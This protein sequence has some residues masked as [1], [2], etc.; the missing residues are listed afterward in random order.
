LN[1]DQ[2]K[3]Y[4]D[5]WVVDQYAE[6][7]GLRRAEDYL[8]ERYF[9]KTDLIYDIG[10][11]AGRTT[12]EISKKGFSIIGMD[13]SLPMI[14][15]CRSRNPNL[16]WQV[17]D[18]CHMPY[19]PAVFDITLFSYNGIDTIVPRKSR[20]DCLLE[21][22]RVTKPGGYLIYSSRNI[23]YR[24]FNRF[25]EKSVWNALRVNLSELKVQLLQNRRL[26]K[27]GYILQ[28]TNLEKQLNVYTITLKKNIRQFQALAPHW[29]LVEVVGLDPQNQDRSYLNNQCHMNYF[30]WQKPP[31]V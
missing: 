21:M 17:N 29:K 28:S 15:H 22:M 16:N 14:E 6:F 1:L 30:V 3:R 4:T 5:K 11:G 7:T 20:F 8:I 13:Y 9:K 24:V 2:N 25:L 31:Q 19:K 27:Q 26:F 18:A 12:L 10:C 23:R